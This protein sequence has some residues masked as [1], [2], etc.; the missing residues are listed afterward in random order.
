[1]DPALGHWLTIYTLKQ[2]FEGVYVAVAGDLLILQ[3]GPEI[4]HF[5]PRH[6]IQGITANTPA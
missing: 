4:T 2:N 5:V 1:M 3:E 6:A